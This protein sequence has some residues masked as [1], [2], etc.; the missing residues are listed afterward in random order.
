[1]ILKIAE[2]KKIL[3][4]AELVERDTQNRDAVDIGSIVKC[5]CLY[6]DEDEPEEEIYE[7]VGH[8]EVDIEAGKIAYDSLVAKN[9]M[10]RKVNDEITF[11]IPS[12][13]VKYTILGIYSDWNE[14]RK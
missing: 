4:E 9:L 6:A 13:E 3:D 7:I 5:S 2:C 14:A 12:G 1:M 10:G 11:N 8:G